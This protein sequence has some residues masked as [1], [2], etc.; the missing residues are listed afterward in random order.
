MNQLKDLFL[1]AVNNNDEAYFDESAQ[2]KEF[3]H[4]IFIELLANSSVETRMELLYKH[5]EIEWLKDNV[6]LDGFVVKS[7]LNTL[8][9][10]ER[11][12]FLTNNL[13]WPY[14][15]END[16]HLDLVDLI[17]AEQFKKLLQYEDFRQYLQKTFFQYNNLDLTF[18]F[19]V[20]ANSIDRID[21]IL[22][23]FV[24]DP[25]EF[26]T[27]T[28]SI[29]SFFKEDVTGTGF[30][31]LMATMLDK[32]P[33]D[34]KLKLLQRYESLYSTTA[35]IN[36]FFGL[37][38]FF[39]AMLANCSD[40]DRAL[41]AILE[42]TELA[43]GLQHSPYISQQA[44]KEPSQ[45]NLGCIAEFERICDE[46]VI[47]NKTNII[48]TF[49]D[50]VANNSKDWSIID[51]LTYITYERSGERYEKF[52]E[53]NGLSKANKALKLNNGTQDNIFEKLISTM[54]AQEWRALFEDIQ[55]SE[56][57]VESLNLV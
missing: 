50:H 7:I 12:E 26:L 6:T 39:E 20:G 13:G 2:S 43:A 34:K 17:S 11:I 24:D 45:F 23:H 32:L 33:F 41:L 27:E 54:T 8:P 25:Y 10:F 48:K 40:R 14:L 21:R 16:I 18:S 49:I 42:N 3:I 38:A 47:Q 19:F 57:Q 1:Y 30:A 5:I 55:Q 44:H 35:K 46:T 9:D 51:I 29:Q 4:E 28:V 31:K 15:T 36:D 37:Q 22:R 56:L 52:K 53:L